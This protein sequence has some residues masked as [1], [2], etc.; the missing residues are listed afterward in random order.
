ME[1]D[2][3]MGCGYLVHSKKGTHIPALFRPLVDVVPPPL[4]DVVELRLSVTLDVEPLQ[5]SGDL[6]AVRVEKQLIST[7]DEAEEVTQVHVPAQD[8]RRQPTLPPAASP[9]R[10]PRSCDAY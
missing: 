8:L 1:D 4:E 9:P 2:R 7:C 10:P 5:E 3:Q 6:Q